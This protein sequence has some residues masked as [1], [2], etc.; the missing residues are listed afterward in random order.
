MTSATSAT[1]QKDITYII[2]L[3]TWLIWRHQNSCIFNNTQPFISLVQT[4]K[5]GA[6]SWAKAGAKGVNMLISE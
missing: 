4:I 6:L 5:D 1:I 3:T 2:L